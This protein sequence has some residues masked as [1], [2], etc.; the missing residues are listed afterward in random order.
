V[1]DIVEELKNYQCNVDV[2]DPWVSAEDAAREY[3]IAPVVTPAE[4]SYDA[5]VLAV[6]HRQ[7]RELGAAAIRKMGKESFVLYDLKYVLQAHESD[8]RL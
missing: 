6:A 8:L 3:D 5:I 1:V 7:F 4:G 2:F